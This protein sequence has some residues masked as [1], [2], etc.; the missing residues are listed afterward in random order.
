MVCRKCNKEF[1]DNL[2]TC[3]YCG[4]RYE[5]EYFSKL[6]EHAMSENTRSAEEIDKLRASLKKKKKNRRRN[7]IIAVLVIA[8]V[9]AAAVG[10]IYY[11]TSRSRSGSRML[12][13][14][15]N[16]N[17]FLVYDENN[18]E[19]LTVSGGKY[20]KTDYSP[21]GSVASCTSYSGFVSFE[22]F[23]RKD[24]LVNREYSFDGV[25]NYV[26]KS[27]E[28]EYD[29]K[30]PTRA[31][32]D[33]NT[34]PGMIENEYDGDNKTAVRSFDFES[35]KEWEYVHDSVGR[36]T[37]EKSYDLNGQLIYNKQYSYKSDGS[38]YLSSVNEVYEKD[39]G[40]NPES[41]KLTS[42]GEDGKVLEETVNTPEGYEIAKAE[43]QFNDKGDVKC[44]KIS[45]SET[46]YTYE[47]YDNGAVSLKA[48]ASAE[49]STDYISYV[50]YDK[51]GRELKNIT[52]Q[53]HF[54]YSYDGS[55]NVTEMCSYSPSAAYLGKTVYNYDGGSLKSETEFDVE[56]NAVNT[57][58]YTPDVNGNPSEMKDS[59]GSYRYINE[60]NEQGDLIDVKTYKLTGEER[61]EYNGIGNVTKKTV[62]NE[63]GGFVAETGYKWL[64]NG[65]ISDEYTYDADGNTLSHVKYHYDDN[66]VQSG[67]TAY[68]ADGS[69]TSEA[70]LSNDDGKKEITLENKDKD[71]NVLYYV[72]YNYSAD[73][74]SLKIS[75]TAGGTGYES[76]YE[77]NDKGELS[78]VTSSRGGKIV[79]K[80]TYTY[81][82]TGNIIKSTSERSDGGKSV[83]EYT[84]DGLYLESCTAV[85]P[86]G[87]ESTVTYGIDENKKPYVISGEK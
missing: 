82:E 19:I 15:F 39:D 1:D 52:A 34:A 32:Y 64:K 14:G 20:T 57:K 44:E 31:V 83:Y 60:Y 8:A 42:Y 21:D 3:P 67:L 71:G 77:Y 47:Y 11:F 65:R 54:E 75:G 79:S 55:G 81:S 27:Y 73:K 85:Y 40:G 66:G 28:Y 18:N 26:Y 86:D 24:G 2:K 61:F 9:A 56:N 87:T 58:E 46:W 69:K 23:D 50:T 30:N 63:L 12:H 78:G 36:L 4:E 5:D 49:N 33:S 6:L 76:V 41:Y 10:A 43:L 59:T 25:K 70:T 48:A 7:V 53:T 51:E 68:A 16:G 13:G 72:K 17:S 29:G 37:A 62:L 45:G 22:R 74:P 35:D 84:Y 80:E 38:L